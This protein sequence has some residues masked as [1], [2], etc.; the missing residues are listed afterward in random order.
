MNITVSFDRRDFSGQVRVEGIGWTAER[1]E[2]QAVGGPWAG[3]LRADPLTG[4][5]GDQLARLWGLADLLRCGVT[6]SDEMGPGWWG[7]GSVLEIHSGSGT[8]RVSL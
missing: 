5:E 4:E 7:Y 2:W 3:R 1:L 8:I 6:V